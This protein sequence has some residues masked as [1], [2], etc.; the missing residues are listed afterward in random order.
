MSQRQ[1]GEKE[2]KGKGLK[3]QQTNKKQKIKQTKKNY[4]VSRIQLY[5]RWGKKHLVVIT[6]GEPIK[7]HYRSAS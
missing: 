7:G 3:H 6:A 1:K 2:H 5:S 4:I